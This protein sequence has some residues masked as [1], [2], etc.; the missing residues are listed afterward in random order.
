MSMPALTLEG[1][2][3]SVVIEVN[4]AIGSVLAGATKCH[5]VAEEVRRNLGGNPSCIPTITLNWWFC[6]GV[7]ALKESQEDLDSNEFYS[8]CVRNMKKHSKE[9]HAGPSLCA[10]LEGRSKVS[11]L[12]DHNEKTS[13]CIPTK[14]ENEG[15][16][17]DEA[18]FDATFCHCSSK[19]SFSS[20]SFLSHLGFDDGALREGN[21]RLWLN[22]QPRVNREVSLERLKKDSSS[23]LGLVDALVRKREEGALESSVKELANQACHI[24]LYALD[25]L[26]ASKNQ[27]SGQVAM[28]CM[29]RKV[30][31]KNT[32]CSGVLR[33]D[34]R[35]RACSMKDMDEIFTQLTGSN[36]ASCVRLDG[37]ASEESKVLLC[38]QRLQETHDHCQRNPDPTVVSN[39]SL[40]GLHV[41]LSQQCKLPPVADNNKAAHKH[42]VPRSIQEME[43][44]ILFMHHFLFKL[45]G[46]SQNGQGRLLAVRHATTGTAPTSLPLERFTRG[47]DEECNLPDE[48]A[49]KLKQQLQQ[50]KVSTTV[51]LPALSENGN[52]DENVI[53]MLHEKSDRD[54]KAF[55]KASAWELVQVMTE[56]IDAM[57]KKEFSYVLKHKKEGNPVQAMDPLIVMRRNMWLALAVVHERKGCAVLGGAFGSV[58][59]NFVKRCLQHKN[60]KDQ[61]AK[62]PTETGPRGADIK[63]GRLLELKEGY[64]GCETLSP[65]ML[66]DKFSG[67][68]DDLTDENI[69]R[70]VKQIV[71][72]TNQLSFLVFHCNNKTSIFHNCIGKKA[73]SPGDP[74]LP[75]C[76]KLIGLLAG[77]LVHDVNSAKVAFAFVNNNGKPSIPTPRH[78]HRAEDKAQQASSLLRSRFSCHSLGSFAFAAQAHTLL[79]RMNLW[80]NGT[81]LI[82]QSPGSQAL[83][84]QW[85]SWKR[86]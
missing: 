61:W 70:L 43:I 12:L 6:D 38:F 41:L 53:K 33:T 79:A 84:T 20:L 40:L 80:Q 25:N 16:A 81:C 39:Q 21:F 45:R 36:T 1:E 59:E 56:A 5:K 58:A 13:A 9:G 11:S 77:H 26:N 62:E 55:D 10:S 3:A 18:S 54:L 63:V 52:W 65:L 75:P 30:S 66:T 35:L 57:I 27:G 48:A 72:D 64:L 44:R 37:I 82:V 51:C 23:E 46:C 29:I 68:E 22:A 14:H 60:V 32:G 42:L 86:A 4:R 83:N 78:A 85:I 69:P 34:A 24:A 19:Q 28:Q 31:G 49:Q 71:N 50:T 17:T 73:V 15:R 74:K 67:D 47:E 2:D 7:E 76:F 8:K